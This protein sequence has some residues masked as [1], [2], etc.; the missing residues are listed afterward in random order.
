MSDL[1][2][3]WNRIVCAMVAGGIVFLYSC[4]LCEILHAQSD[5]ELLK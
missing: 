1:K 2:S 5:I 3:I 4:A